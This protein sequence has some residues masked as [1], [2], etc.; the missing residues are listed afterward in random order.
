MSSDIEVKGGQL[1]IRVLL[2]TDLKADTVIVNFDGTR[3]WLKEAF[4]R[5]GKRIG[6]IDCCLE[7]AP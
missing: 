1:M 5:G 4:D 7:S 3:A 6:V 2:G